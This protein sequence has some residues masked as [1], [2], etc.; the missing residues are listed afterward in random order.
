[1]TKFRVSRT[2]V[3]KWDEE[4]HGPRE[5][6]LSTLDEMLAWVK[7]T[8]HEVIISLD[9]TTRRVENPNYDPRNPDNYGKPQYIREKVPGSEYWTLEIYD[10]YRE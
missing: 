6:E 4:V 7:D 8:N 10:G 3:F 5:V 9:Y 1:M 2:C